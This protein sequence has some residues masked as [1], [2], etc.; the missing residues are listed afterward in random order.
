[1]RRPDRSLYAAS[2]PTGAAESSTKESLGIDGKRHLTLFAGVV[3]LHDLQRPLDALRL[4]H[5]PE[6]RSAAAHLDRDPYH[7]LTSS[8]QIPP[9]PA[10]QLYFTVLTV[11]S[12]IM[13]G[14]E[15]Q[16]DGRTGRLRGDLV[17]EA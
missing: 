3:P 17:V 14:V 15:D 13:Q 5:H 6:T 2:C 9:I 1:M 7:L 11:S 16:P 4:H 10:Y 8:A 12:E